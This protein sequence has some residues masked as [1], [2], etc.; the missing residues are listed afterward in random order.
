MIGFIGLFVKEPWLLE[1]VVVLYE[2][3]LLSRKSEDTGKIWWDDG[4]V[5][6]KIKHHI[7]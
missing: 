1:G 3:Q 2:R 7:T 6:Y 5:L 4:C